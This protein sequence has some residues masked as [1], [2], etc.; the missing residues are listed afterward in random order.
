MEL[1]HKITLNSSIME[2]GGK[3]GSVNG[4]FQSVRK[5]FHLPEKGNL[6]D[7]MPYTD[8]DARAHEKCNLIME[9]YRKRESMLFAN[10]PDHNTP[11]TNNGMERFFRK[12]RR[13]IRKRTDSSDTGNIL[14]KSGVKTALFQNMGNSKYLQAVFGTAKEEGI[15]S[16]FEKNMKP[17]KKK[18]KTV[19]ETR[20]LVE[21]DRRM[22][23]YQSP[24]GT[25]YTDEL[26]E[27]A[28][29]LRMGSHG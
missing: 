24:S 21:E 18:K 8:S 15:A 28:K 25:P 7:E 12:I 9:R 10:S 6:S 29:A 3:L 27:R 17:F 2:T 20:R 13:N 16:V 14:S 19:K 22:I 11:W 5:A 1:V 26:F 4:M 23:V